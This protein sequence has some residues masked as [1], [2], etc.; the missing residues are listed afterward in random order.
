MVAA[1]QYKAVKGVFDYAEAQDAHMLTL[2]APGQAGQDAPEAPSRAPARDTQARDGQMQDKPG[3]DEPE[4][5]ESP[6]DNP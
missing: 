5:D 2:R 3:Q 6:H 1:S 4:Q